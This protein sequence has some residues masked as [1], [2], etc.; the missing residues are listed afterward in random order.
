[1]SRI[2]PLPEADAV[3]RVEQTYG[4]L[5]DLLEVESLPEPILQFGRNEAFL[6]DFYMNFKKF[7]WAD[8]ALDAKQK[9]CL[10]Y[11]TA[12]QQK[13]GAWID[14]LSGR[15]AKLGFT[16]DD[17]IGI[18]AIVST[19]AMYNTFFQVRE[20][21][22]SDLFGGMPVGLRAHTF[23]GDRARRADCRTD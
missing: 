22:G 1:M 19:N 8:G 9:T 10:A 16:E 2:S 12:C 14:M 3:D 17:L 21:S 13:C 7:V 15:A 6:R 5:K 11:A 23:A 4:R 18:A 20:L